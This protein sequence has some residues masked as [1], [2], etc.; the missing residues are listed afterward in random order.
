MRYCRHITGFTLLEF[1]V[2][3][4][5]GLMLLSGAFALVIAA[6]K[7]SEAAM[8]AQ[9]QQN[10][11]MSAMQLLA[12]DIASA[13]AFGCSRAC[14]NALHWQGMHGDASALSLAYQ[15]QPPFR[16]LQVSDNRLHIR[17]DQDNHFYPNEVLLITQP[18]EAARVSVHAGGRGQNLT[19]NAPFTLKTLTG[20]MVGPEVVH[21]YFYDAHQKKL[22]MKSGQGEP[23][24]LLNEVSAFSFTYDVKTAAGVVEKQPDTDDAWNHVCGVNV[25]LT[26]SG[27]TWVRYMPVLSHC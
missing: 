9:Q 18:D 16:L 4:T 27:Q 23:L 11:I 7:N 2:S 13:G 17:V 10:E 12:N 24:T 22:Q 1:M 6:M 8:Q 20:A 15:A 14:V 26:V 19:L 21:A 25:V 3:M 5:L